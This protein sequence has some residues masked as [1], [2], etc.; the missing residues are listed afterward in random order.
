MSASCQLLAIKREKK[1]RK[2]EKL[3]LK[4]RKPATDRDNLTSQENR[5]RDILHAVIGEGERD[6]YILN[7]NI[8]SL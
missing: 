1:R 4:F 8:R 5:S 2:K 6:K 7:A 3:K